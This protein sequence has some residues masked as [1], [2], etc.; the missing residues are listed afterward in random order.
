MI[1]KKSSEEKAEKVFVHRFGYKYSE[2][3]G[4]QTFFS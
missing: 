1:S 3:E 2:T 4:K